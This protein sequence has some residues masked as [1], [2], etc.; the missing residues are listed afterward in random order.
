[1]GRYRICTVR[2]GTNLQGTGG[3]GYARILMKKARFINGLEGAESQP[4]LGSAGRS[5]LCQRLKRFTQ[6]LNIFLAV[7]S[8]GTFPQRI[9]SNAVVRDSIVGIGDDVFDG[10][11]WPQ[12][13]TAAV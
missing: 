13:Y 4:K 3:D 5:W 12:F 6:H 7:I 10:L 9:S 2:A 11:S 1:M 8:E